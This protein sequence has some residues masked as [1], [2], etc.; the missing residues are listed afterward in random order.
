MGNEWEELYQQG[1]N[2]KEGCDFRWLDLWS[3]SCFIPGDKGF[4]WMKDVFWKLTSP[5]QKV[6][7]TFAG[8][9]ATAKA[10]MFLPRHLHY[11]RSEIDINCIEEVLLGLV[12]VFARNILNYVAYIVR[13]VGAQNVAKVSVSAIRGLATRHNKQIWDA[14]TFWRPAQSFH[15]QTT[16]LLFICLRYLS[17]Y[18]M[19]ECPPFT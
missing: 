4:V 2:S 13:V 16:H 1:F 6:F 17:S 11:V 7:D 15:A 3:P 8:T 9:F 19:A 5:V 12:E 14:P 18:A 10:Y